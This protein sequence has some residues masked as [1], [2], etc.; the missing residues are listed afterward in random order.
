MRLKGARPFGEFTGRTART[1]TGT[2]TDREGAAQAEEP[3]VEAAVW[4]PGPRVV[5]QEVRPEATSEW[6]Y[7]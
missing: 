3:G 2:G 4:G 6:T 7:L 5:S 1:G